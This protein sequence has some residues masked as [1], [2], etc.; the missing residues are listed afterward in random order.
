MGYAA[1]SSCFHPPQIVLMANTLFCFPPPLSPER[2]TTCNRVHWLPARTRAQ[3]WIR[4]CKFVP[5]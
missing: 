5:F 2:H 4:T 1:V 3:S